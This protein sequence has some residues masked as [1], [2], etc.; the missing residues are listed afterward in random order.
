[1]KG[2][3]SARNYSFTTGAT[4]LLMVNDV[5]AGMKRTDLIVTNTSAAAV[6]SMARGEAPAIN[7]EGIRLSVNSGWSDSTD[8]GRKCWQGQIQIISDVAGTV[9]VSE[10]YEEL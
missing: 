4:S 9:S 5:P 10:G 7:G 1:M 3:Q 8:S 6:I 2:D